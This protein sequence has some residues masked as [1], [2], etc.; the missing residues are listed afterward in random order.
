MLL[1]LL[2]AA[3]ITAL[4]FVGLFQFCHMV[5]GWLMSEAP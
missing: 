3:G 4:L 5:I 1:A 2:S